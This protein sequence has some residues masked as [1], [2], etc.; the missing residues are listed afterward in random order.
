MDDKTTEKQIFLAALKVFQ[1]KGLAGARM[2]EIADEAGINKSMLHYY[3]RSKEK[4]FNEVFKSSI[5]EFSGK[6][7]AILDAD[8]S[9]WEDKIR[10]IC[11]L[12][13]DF[14]I[15][16]PDLAL[17]IINEM[18][19]EPDCLFAILQMDMCLMK[20]KFFLQLKA[21]MEKGEIRKLDPM[22][23]FVSLV[24]EIVHPFVS[25]SLIRRRISLPQEEWPQ[26]LEERK[27]FVA[28]MLIT[29][30]KTK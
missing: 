11:H 19:Q 18:N 27:Q 24:S 25:G 17:F 9:S 28:D 3:Y 8:N 2:Q 29:Y 12:H 6:F 13:S 7:Q 5:D 30:L 16:N 15:A 26:F 23:L 21:A 10:D 1:K 14:M 22:Q 4:L 20:S